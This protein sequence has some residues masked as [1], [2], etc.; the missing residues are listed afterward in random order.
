[1]KH[2]ISRVV[3]LRSA[4]LG[5]GVEQA[6]PDSAERRY[7]PTRYDYAL[8]KVICITVIITGSWRRQ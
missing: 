6:G 7:R 3:L 4:S 5:H 1:M 2:A 8:L